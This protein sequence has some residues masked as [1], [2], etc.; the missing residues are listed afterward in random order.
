MAERRRESHNLQV[1][2]YCGCLAS[3]RAQRSN[4]DS[5][6]TKY[7]LL[8][9]CAPRNDEKTV[10]SFA[11][12]HHL[13]RFCLT[14][15]RV[16]GRGL[17]SGTSPERIAPESV[18]RLHSGFVH[19]NMSRWRPGRGTRSS[20]ARLHKGPDGGSILKSCEHCESNQNRQR[21]N[22]IHL[23]RRP[24]QASPCEREPGPTPRDLSLARSG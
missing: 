19:R 12:W 1:F 7:G 24:G 13:R 11:V 15:R 2:L 10:N 14:L 21:V 9:R 5:V 20:L 4:P 8:R 18:T 6:M 22:R 16:S 17:S 23:P 3:L